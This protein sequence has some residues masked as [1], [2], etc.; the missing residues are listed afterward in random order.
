[1]ISTSYRSLA[2][3][4]VNAHTRGVRKA[5]A[6]D[7]KKAVGYIRVSTDR[8]EHGPAAQRRS[9]ESWAAANGVELV[10]IVEEAES[11]AAEAADRPELQAALAAVRVRGAGI[12]L[13]TKR[14]RVARDMVVARDIGERARVSGAKIITVDG[15]SDTEN[16]PETFLRQGIADLFAEHERKQIAERTKNALAAMKTKG[17][18]TGNPL[19][20][21]Q[22]AAAGPL[23]KASRRPLRLVPHEYEQRI[24]RFVMALHAR[25]TSPAGITRELSVRRARNRAGKPFSQEQVQ[26]IISNA[27][28]RADLLALAK[29]P[30]T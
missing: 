1:M 25:Q 29:E 16:R 26:R 6:G 9:L 11:G 3:R 5:P 12:L 19:Y 28:A 15:M 18:R 27:A 14:D 23:S 7:P 17:L 20:G 10:E 13:A 22:C 8:Q 21:F 2:G 4:L 24:C 30:S